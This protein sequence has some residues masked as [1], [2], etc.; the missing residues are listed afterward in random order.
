MRVWADKKIGRRVYGAR[1]VW[2]QLRREGIEVAR[3]TVERLMSELGIPGAAARRKKPRTTVPAPPAYPPSITILGEPA[4]L[5][6]SRNNCLY[7]R[8]RPAAADRAGQ[9]AAS[10]H[11]G[12]CAKAV[13]LP[14]AS[15]P[16]QRGIICPSPARLVGAQNS[17]IRNGIRLDQIRAPG[18]L[19]RRERANAARTAA[20]AGSS[21]SQG[22]A[23]WP[24]C[25]Q[26]YQGW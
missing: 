22:N 5:G 19:D 12:Y 1:K 20:G 15:T 17:Q 16:F 11:G 24:C 14:W 18:R 9:P 10:R 8:G 26:Q 13:P 3:C 7:R 25:G 2:R 4:G 21:G 6:H 23:L